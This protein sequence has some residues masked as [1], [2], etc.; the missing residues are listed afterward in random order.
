MHPENIRGPAN[1]DEQEQKVPQKITA[2]T[3]FTCEEGWGE[4]ENV[5]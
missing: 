4:G 3:L 5:R 1:L 2:F